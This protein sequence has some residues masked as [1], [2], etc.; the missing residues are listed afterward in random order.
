[1]TKSKKPRAKKRPTRAR[2]PAYQE[3]VSLLADTRTN[4]KIP[5]QA[6]ADMMGLAQTDISK[7][8]R[9]DRRLDFIEVL[10]ILYLLAGND[11]KEVSAMLNKIHNIYKHHKDVKTMTSG[12]MRLKN[13]LKD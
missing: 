10:D 8:E 7:I 12:K 1:M 2:S 5:Q 11:A 4:A 6:I 9:T 3:M 13:S